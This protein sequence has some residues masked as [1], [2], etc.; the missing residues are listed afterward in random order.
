MCVLV[1]VSLIVWSLCLVL[2][3]WVIS[4]NCASI[5]HFNFFNMG[6]CCIWIVFCYLGSAVFGLYFCNLFVQ[7]AV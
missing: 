5:L 7:L 3:L 2:G 6:I 1:F 4:K